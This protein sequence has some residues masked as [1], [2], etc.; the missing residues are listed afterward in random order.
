[1]PIYGLGLD[2]L[3]YVFIVLQPL[4]GA[5]CHIVGREKAKLKVLSLFAA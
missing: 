5:L 2:I 1:M 4:V 3:S